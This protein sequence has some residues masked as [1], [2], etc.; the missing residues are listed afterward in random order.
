MYDLVII[1]GGPG[2]YVCAI[3][4]AQNGLKVACVEK[5]QNLGG[6]CLNEGCIPSKAL[7]ESSHNFYN[8]KHHFTEH[9]ISVNPKIDTSVMLAR[10]DG[11]IKSLAGG[12]DM[13]FRK[14]K[15]DKITGT[16]RFVSKNEIEVENNGVKTAIRS[17]KFVIA[18]GSVVSQIPNVAI[19]EEN[20]VSS[21]GALC[22]KKVPQELVVI[23]GGVIGLELGCV[24]SR[25]GANTKV[26]EYSDKIIP[27]MDDDVSEYAKKMLDAQGLEIHTSH[28]V[29]SVEKTSKNVKIEYEDIK[30]GKRDFVTCDVVLVCIGRRPFTQGL[31]LE[32]IGGEIDSRGFIKVDKEYK[33]C[34]NIFAI[35]DVIPGPMLAH[36]AEDEG[37]AV[38]DIAAGKYGHVNYNAIPSV[39]YTD[40]EIACV[41]LSEK[42]LK[43]AN[44]EY[45]IGK[46]NFAANSRAKA[47][48]QTQGFVKIIA[49]KQTDRILGASIIGKEAGT[50]IHEI[51]VLIEFS[52]SAEDLSM[53]CHAHPTL[54]EA[55]K[56]AAL[57]VS[58]RAIHS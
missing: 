16:A 35:G 45:K 49:D 9:G 37:I 2:G 10:K 40:P 42:A 58:K 44:I 19:D 1:G 30:T 17:A 39:V 54:N 48:S 23:G 26:L 7:L 50:L 27:G 22:L 47:I 38:A 11:I 15:I 41:G 14:N 32:A 28:K 24:W 6:T 12:I 5:R 46:F 4:A 18:T 33:V 13:L 21:T 57:A 55:I 25:L 51:S 53:I 3:R 56:E 36:K 8:A 31:N 29:L 52:A 20:I 43:D 34:E